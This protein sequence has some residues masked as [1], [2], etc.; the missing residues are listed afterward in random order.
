V[1]NLR[2]QA[3]VGLILTIILA[4]IFTSLQAFEYNM[5]DF[6]LSDGIYGSTFYMATG[7]HGFH[8]F[9][10]TI[11]LLVCLIRLTKYQLT[12]QHHFGFEAAA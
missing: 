3:I 7:F 6:R 5:A 12:Q 10:G 4:T 8:V 9:V 1:A 2:T 11:F